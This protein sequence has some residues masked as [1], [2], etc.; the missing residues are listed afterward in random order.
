MRRV[1]IVDDEET[2]R[3]LVR[4]TLADDDLELA[5]AADGTAA[6]AAV[7]QSPPALVVLDVSMPGPSGFEVLQTLRGDPRHAAVRVVMLTARTQAADREAALAAGADAFVSK[8]FS[9]GELRRIV[10]DLLEEERA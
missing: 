6:L 8:P 10:R 5:E 1:L 9:P 7:E 3:V 4:A 2:L